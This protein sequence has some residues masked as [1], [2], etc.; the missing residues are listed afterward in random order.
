MQR[1]SGKELASL[2][3]SQGPCLFSHSA[4]LGE[5]RGLL[6]PGIC[7]ARHNLDCDYFC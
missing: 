4:G 1:G 7:L 2:G 6:H 3:E 5:I